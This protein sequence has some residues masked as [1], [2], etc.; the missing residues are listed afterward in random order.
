M[1][2]YADRQ[3]EITAIALGVTASDGFALAGSG[4]IREHGLIDRP[5]EDID[6]FTVRQASQQFDDAV[7]RTIAA[8][9]SNGY[10][11]A[12]KIRADGFA[13][14]Q[15]QSS[16]GYE[17]EIDL[18]IDWRSTPPVHLSIGNVLAEQ[19]A[20]GSK[21]AAL[22]SRGEARDYLDVDAIRRN[23]SYSDRDLIDLAEQSDQGFDLD[24]FHDVLLRV[25]LLT[26]EEIEP[27]DL[28]VTEL[29]SI[30]TRLL[31]FAD[32][33]DTGALSETK[34]RST[35]TH[36]TRSKLSKILDER[37]AAKF[38]DSKQIPCKSV[39]RAERR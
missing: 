33:I 31:S 6:L 30:K 8:L 19:D 22:F 5:T 21:V 7:T 38:D 16:D 37:A 10:I 25:Q 32:D 36:N 2:A 39:P 15:V 28:D 11:V 17:T 35:N 29:D 9:C 34:R 14:L 1:N 3:R 26:S 18:G 4:A 20:V 23:G 27:Y 24:M 13:R 12:D